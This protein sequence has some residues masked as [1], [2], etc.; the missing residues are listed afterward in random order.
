[1]TAKR[2]ASAKKRRGRL[3]RY[4]ELYLLFLPVFIWY[5]I[6]CYL[7]M[8]GLVIAFKNFTPLKG[9]FGSNWVG[10]ANFIKIFSAPSFLTAVKK[11]GYYQPFKL[12]NRLPDPYPVCDPFE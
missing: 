11:Y 4:W 7:P 9:V 6:Y 3:A 10:M 2:S 1:M 5:I 12:G 8:G